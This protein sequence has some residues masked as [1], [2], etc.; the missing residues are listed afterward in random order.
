MEDGMNQDNDEEITQYNV[1]K[2]GAYIPVSDE[3]LA[4]MFTPF[5]P[6]F[7]RRLLR[8]TRRDKIRAWWS[9]KVRAVRLGTAKKIAGKY[10][11][12]DH[13]EDW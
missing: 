1:R 7:E 10:G 5:T 13:D 8:P 3:L 9:Q 11:L 2:Y 12:C 4:D 6:D